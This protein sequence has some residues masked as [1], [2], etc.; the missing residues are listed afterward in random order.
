MYV[1]LQTRSC[2]ACDSPKVVDVSS[3]IVDISVDEI[4]LDW[5]AVACP[6][7]YF[8]QVRHYAVSFNKW[9]SE[10]Y[11]IEFDQKWAM[12]VEERVEIESRLLKLGSVPIPDHLY[13]G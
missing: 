5:K 2:S 3:D 9:R 10:Q 4:S 8:S 12:N 1:H 7:G 6:C 11:S 13:V